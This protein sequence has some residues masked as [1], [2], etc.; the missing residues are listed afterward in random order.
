[1]LNKQPPNKQVW[2]SSPISG[3]KRFDWVLSVPGVQNS[4]DHKQDTEGH[5]GA[6]G[7]DG[8]LGGGRWTY[9]RDGTGLSEV[10]KDELAVELFAEN[11]TELGSKE[12]V[13]AGEGVKSEM[14]G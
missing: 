1:M 5:T 9:M 4:M 13:I 10:L 7:D 12:S 6:M 2:L 11:T 14:L 3:P 8:Q